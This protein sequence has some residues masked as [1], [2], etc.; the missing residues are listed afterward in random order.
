MIKSLVLAAVT[1]VGAL[2][3]PSANAGVSWSVN[4]NTPIVGTVISG[5]PGYY[6]S[7]YGRG[8]DRVYGPEPVYAPAPVYY[9][10]APPPVAYY[11]PRVIYAPVPV[12]YP[13]Y[14]P[15]YRAGWRH[16]HDR[17]WGGHG[18]R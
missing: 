10:R 16:G 5:G 8:Y 12:V 11:P 15:G 1:T 3:A 2:V 6:G 17:R 13:R 7:G 9:H 18:R 4:L 14:S